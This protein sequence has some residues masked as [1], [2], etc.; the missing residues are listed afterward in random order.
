[1]C[2]CVV[3]V[4]FITR[5]VAAVGGVVIVNCRVCVVERLD[6]RVVVVVVY[7]LSPL[8]GI[9]C[10]VVSTGVVAVVVVVIVVITVVV[11]IAVFGWRVRICLLY[12]CR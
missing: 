2:V 3:V 7:V 4:A 11:Y 1:M 12:W 9:F 6:F 10:C 5:G 8:F